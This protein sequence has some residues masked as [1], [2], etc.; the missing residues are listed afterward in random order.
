MRWSETRLASVCVSASNLHQPIRSGMTSLI[1]ASTHLP[2]NNTPPA[3]ARY[4]QGRVRVLSR[5]TRLDRCVYALLCSCLFRKFRSAPARSSLGERPSDERWRLWSALK[6]RRR[7]HRP[8]GS[9][10]RCSLLWAPE[11]LL[12]VSGG[13]PSSMAFD[14][15]D[16]AAKTWPWVLLF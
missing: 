16:A 9:L 10:S 1:F 5:T 11:H 3:A 2:T 6:I 13:S 8:G 4:A 12:R 15:P 14:A 7:E